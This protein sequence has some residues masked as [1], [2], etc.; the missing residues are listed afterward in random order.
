[1]VQHAIGPPQGHTAALA[2][3]GVVAA[4]AVV[5]VF[6]WSPFADYMTFGVLGLAVAVFAALTAASI[7]APGQ[8]RHALLG[9]ALA[10]TP[11]ALLVYSFQRRT[12]GS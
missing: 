5:A 7:S 8:R 9:L 6:A 11:V 4:L 2:A 1:M 3:G 10:L 12:E